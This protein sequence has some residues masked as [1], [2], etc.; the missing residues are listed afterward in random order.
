M[1]TLYSANQSIDK[2]ANQNYTSFQS[3]HKFDN[4][5]FKDFKND[6]IDVIIIKTQ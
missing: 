1:P 2:F 3:Q 4:T 6:Q 5:R